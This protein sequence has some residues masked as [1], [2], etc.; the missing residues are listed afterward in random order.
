[1][2]N[3]NYS[4]TI[5]VT[6]EYDVI[7][8]GAGPAGICAAVQAA[9]LGAKV[10]LVERYGILG[11][12]LTSGHVGPILGMVGKGTMRDELVELLGVPDN[13]MIGETGVAHDMEK[14]KR[15]LLEFVKSDNID[16]L[17]QTAA[18]DVVK[19]ADCVR[20]LVISGKEGMSAILAGVTIDA[21]GDGDVC[22]MAG[23]K[24]EKGRD[25]GLMQPV[26]LEF[27]IDGLDESRAIAC[28]GDVDDVKL[29]RERFLDFCGRCGEEG[30]LPKEIVAVR[31][32]RT[33]RPGE[34]NVN[35]TQANGVD[36]T[37][38]REIYPAEVKM[39]EQIEILLDFF[40]KYLPGYENCRL[41]STPSTTG[42]RESRRVTGEYVVTAEEL[43]SGKRFEDVIVHNAEFIVDIHN[44]SGAGQA[45]AQIQ[46]V[47]PYDL[48]YGCFVPRDVDGL[49]MAGRCIS[50]THRAHASYRVMSI[51]M[52]MGQAV[53]AAAALCA[54]HG[55][56][57]KKLPVSTVQK[58]LAD[59]GV[60]L[61]G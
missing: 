18:V 25:D 32:H 13:D 42:V 41:V 51:C 35:T 61:F 31:L 14:A 6:G 38:T 40:R 47:K 59:L 28:I 44:P 34:R 30:I 52:A 45:E 17:V 37:I 2:R 58:A 5:A 29:G 21:T 43:A 49:M 54:K 53:G 10:C 33:T 55:V 22:A 20:G 8:A 3:I 50:G 16:V 48:P 15:T 12:M 24:F 23:A 9:R 26:T 27:L 4:R 56:Q 60:D 39:R 19:D 11:G 1:M 57:P 7:V 46:Y 36:A